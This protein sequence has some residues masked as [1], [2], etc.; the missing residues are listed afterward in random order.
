MKNVLRFTTL[1]AVATLLCSTAPAQE[2]S[3]RSTQSG[4]ASASATSSA[5]EQSARPW[6]EAQ[7]QEFFRAS[8]LIGKNTQDN[9]AK[10]VGEIKDVVFN[11]QGEIFALVDVGSGRWAAVPLQVL[12]M[13][14]A[15]GNDPLVLETT[16]QAVSSAPLV[17]KDQWGALNNPAFARGIYSYFKVQ[18]PGTGTAMGG[19]SDTDESTQGH[20]SS[21]SSATQGGEREPQDK[22]HQDDQED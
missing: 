20:G 17:T 13:R 3:D 18:S 21:D 11:Q 10:K 5:A 19:T 16:K 22:E 8:D 7:K 6:K 15:K 4:S 2:R 14:S 1:G 12:R 9:Q